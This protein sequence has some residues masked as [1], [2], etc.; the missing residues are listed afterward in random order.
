MASRQDVIDTI[1]GNVTVLGSASRGATNSGITVQLENGN[2]L[3][4]HDVPV[5][6]TQESGSVTATTQNV[7]VEYDSGGN[8]VQAWLGN[9]IAKDWVAPVNREQALLDK[10]TELETAMGG[11]VK[12][13]PASLDTLGIRY[14]VFLAADNIERVQA[15]LNGTVVIRETC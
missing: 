15:T 3:E 13:N 2:T 14:L 5:Y 1:T 4:R 7:F 10:F 8:E 6:I 12:I 9:R 11:Q